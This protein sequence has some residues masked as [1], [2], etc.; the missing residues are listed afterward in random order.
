MASKKLLALILD[1][2]SNRYLRYT[3]YINRLCSEN[4]CTTIEPLFAYEGIR[5]AILTGLDVR[6]SKIWHD[7]VFVP[8]GRKDLRI[9]LLET[10][11]PIIDRASPNDFINKTLRYILFK[12]LQED[13]G[14]PHLIP[15]HYLRYFKTYTHTNKN[16]P[17]LF[18]TLSQKGVR[19]AWIE[20]RLSLMEG[21]SLGKLVKYFRKY[22]LIMLKLNSLDRLGHEYGPLSNEVRRKVEYLDSM[23]EKSFYILSREYD[24]FFFIIMSDHGMTPVRKTVDIEKKLYTE[25][26]SK[27]LRDYIPYIGSTFASF[28]F[29][30]DNA[31][32]EITDILQKLN[33]YGRILTDE[34]LNI[35]G[36]NRKLYGH[37][38]FV[39][40]EG[41]VF[42]PNFFQKRN[43][44]KGMHGY[45]KTQYDK[46]VLITNI[47]KQIIKS[48]IKPSSEFT[49][50]PRI[51]FKFFEDE[52]R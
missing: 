7:K 43:P 6:E 36:I 11:T 44:P 31:R 16:V 35:L 50:I 22:D 45:F 40:N 5:V 41:I 4:Y 49:T 32:E 30:N 1:A 42:F 12:I 37:M 28:W 8:Q 15:A 3:N 38:I 13:Y 18:Q 47:D 48:V 20:P 34:E 46:P 24:K 51:L 27:P 29:F 17:D 33:D 25:I 21:T 19:S 14:T 2:F 39:I 26:N 52:E 9:K 10:L 23:I